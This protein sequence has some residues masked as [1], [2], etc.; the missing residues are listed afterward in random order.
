MYV[1]AAVIPNWSVPLPNISYPKLGS[2]TKILSHAEA[3]AGV[4][5]R[6]ANI[7]GVLDVVTAPAVLILKLK[8]V[9]WIV[10]VA[11]PLVANDN[12]TIR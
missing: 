3:V 5:D 6:A 11:C 1:A 7:I 10:A 4:A 12:A 9:V 8:V 2:G